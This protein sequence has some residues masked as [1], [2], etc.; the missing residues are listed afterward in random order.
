MMVLRRCKGFVCSKHCFQFS[1]VRV[2]APHRPPEFCHTADNLES[3]VS[4]FSFLLAH[5]Y[6]AM[7]SDL[8]GGATSDIE[9]TL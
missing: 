9:E 2:T 1:V 7:Y 6:L 8:I 4:F 5:R 3:R